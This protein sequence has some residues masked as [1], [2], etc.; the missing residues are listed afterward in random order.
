MRDLA[1]K[2]AK[3]TRS[4]TKHSFEFLKGSR[5]PGLKRAQTTVDRE[6]AFSASPDPKDKA[7]VQ[8]HIVSLKSKILAL[9]DDVPRR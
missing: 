3:P 2:T 8:S 5:H 9:S 4:A 7:D 6:R 1:E